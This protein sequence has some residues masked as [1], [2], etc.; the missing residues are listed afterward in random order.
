M[1][2]ERGRCWGLY[3]GPILCAREPDDGQVDGFLVDLQQQRESD[4][5]PDRGR[6]GEED[7]RHEGHEERDL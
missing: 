4:A 2:G 7:R 6:H 1:A 5:D 3:Q